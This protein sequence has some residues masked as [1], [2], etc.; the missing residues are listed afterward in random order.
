MNTQPLRITLLGTGTSQG[1]PVIG[2]TCAVCSSDD[3]RDKRLRTALLIEHGN[4]RI[5]ID[6]GP[7]FRQQMLRA[8]VQ[9]LD[10]V[11]LT[12]EHNDHI[13]GMDDVRPFNFRQRRHMPVYGLPRVLDSVQTRFAYIFDA[14][15]YPGAPRLELR[16][17]QALQPFPVNELTV[18]PFAVEHGNMEVLGFRF[19][20]FTYI[21]DMKTISPENLAAIQ[22][23]EVL[24]L[25]ALH[26]NPHFSHLN[27]EEALAFIEKLG[28][29]ATYL[30][31]ISHH[32]GRYEAI[33]PQ[34]PQGVSLGWDGLVLE[35]HP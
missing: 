23:T 6:T 12:H 35:I 10:A 17:I 34:L 21:T 14:E 15:P 25:N 5:A 7:D 33:E 29:K 13:I 32:M 26:H 19:G 20:P 9:E 1:V 24:I 18:L 30:T 2:C 22:G 28:P 31:H 27:L 3:P 11:L 8:K 16:P 4:T